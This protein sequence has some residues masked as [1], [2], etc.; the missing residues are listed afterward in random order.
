MDSLLVYY[1]QKKQIVV[2]CDVSPLGFGAVLSHIMPD[3]QER[4]IAYA[5]Q[6]L[7]AAERGYMQPK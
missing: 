2:A 7:T 6:T 4:P 5:S 1:D 3:G